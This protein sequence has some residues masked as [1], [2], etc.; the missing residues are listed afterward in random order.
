[1]TGEPHQQPG[2]A[3]PLAVVALV[4]LPAVCCAALVLVASGALAITGGWLHNPWLIV[5]AAL[6]L[7]SGL[8]VLIRRFAASEREAR[9][10]SSRALPGNPQDRPTTASGR[11][12]PNERPDRPV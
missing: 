6:V 11:G 12:V 8:A 4:V 10:T 5:T 2:R 9:R 3:G 1:M 7:L